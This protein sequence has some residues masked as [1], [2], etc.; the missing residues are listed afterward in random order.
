VVGAL[1][2]ME[3][4]ERAR[5]DGAERGSPVRSSDGEVATGGDAKEVI[6]VGWA[7]V[8]GNVCADLSELEG[9]RGMRMSTQPRRRNARGVSSPW[10][11]EI[12]GDV[13]P[14]S[15]EEQHRRGS[16]AEREGVL[17]VRCDGR[18]EEGKMGCGGIGQ[19]L[20]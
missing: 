7:P 16:E 5:Q 20:I 2:P 15:G 10:R 4:G 18:T 6:S 11:G 8:I 19:R 3:Q 17:V 12:G 13:G 14:G 1:A 9:R